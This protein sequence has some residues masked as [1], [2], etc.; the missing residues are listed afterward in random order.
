LIHLQYASDNSLDAYPNEEVVGQKDVYFLSFVFFKVG[1][2]QAQ[3]QGKEDISKSYNGF[4]RFKKALFHN[5]LLSNKNYIK[6]FLFKA[7]TRHQ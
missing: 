6:F 5:S 1:M 2:Y 7:S 4:A 3:N